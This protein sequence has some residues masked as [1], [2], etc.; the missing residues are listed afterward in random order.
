MRIRAAPQSGRRLCVRFPHILLFAFACACL[1]QHTNPEI[2]ECIEQV[3]LDSL[4]KTVRILSGED[5]VW[6]G[7]SL[8]RIAE[9]M[10]DPDNEEAA[11]YIHRR[12]AAYGLSVHNQQYSE[13]GL[14]VIAVQSGSGGPGKPIMLCA[15]YDAVDFYCADD[16]ASG[17]AAVLEAARILSR[18]KLTRPLLYAFWDEEETGKIGSMYYASGSDPGAPETGGVINLEMFGWDGNGD[19]VME[20]H[21]RDIANSDS[22]ADVLVRIDSAYALSL[23]PVV[24][25]PGAE[26]SD[27][28]SFWAHGFGAVAVTQAYWGG[29]FNPFYHS[30]EDRIARFNLPYFR[31]LTRLAVGA[32]AALTLSAPD[33]DADPGPSMPPDGFELSNAPNPFNASTVIQYRIPRDGRVRLSVCDIRGRRIAVLADGFQSAGTHRTVFHADDLAGGVYVVMLRTA[34]HVRSRKLML[35]K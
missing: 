5:S 25:N 19:S 17:A 13:T 11:E 22:L 20:I 21:A 9:R 1:A 33:A 4:V 34:E 32:A 27:H 24:Y 3:S 10:N 8:V 12:L 26:G 14:N 16:N 7:D 35:I 2:Q 28:G 6:M 23:N 30:S 15:H 31:E 29:D 18:R